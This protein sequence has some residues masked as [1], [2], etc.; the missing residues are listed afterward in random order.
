M[1][2]PRPVLPDT[3]YFI[4]RTCA[5]RQFL[6]RPSV[7]VRTVIEYCLGYAARRHGVLLHALCV[8]SNHI[9]M[10]VT[11]VRGEL[12]GFM[13]W[14]NGYVARS[15]NRHYQRSE[16]FFSPGSY[17]RVEPVHREDVLDKMAYTLA[18]P[19]AAGLVSH[20]ADWPGVRSGTFTNGA[21]SKQCPRPGFFFRKKSKLPEGVTVRFERPSGFEELS[22]REFA[23]R[24]A[25]AVERLERQA[26]DRIRA[27]GRRFLGVEGVLAQDPFDSPRTAR[28]SSPI[29][30][31]VA[32]KDRKARAEKLRALAEWL[33]AYR[34]AACDFAIGIRD[35][36][37]P[38]GT[39]WMRLHCSVRCEPG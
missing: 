18:N 24:Y 34:A 31:R 20:G 2:L 36:L 27:A 6:L 21:Y 28:K 26:R 5:Q 7:E 1:S 16:N 13:E 37:F 17:S 10:V 33:Q 39:Y 14:F 35:V 4:T 8:M 3:S 30:P 29:R 23:E 38:P 15:L 19:V 9:H 22:D 32:A 11:D 12:P 25:Q